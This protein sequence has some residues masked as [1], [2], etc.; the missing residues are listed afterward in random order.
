MKILL[1]C[2]SLVC[3]L[4]GQGPL[5]MLRTSS[6]LVKEEREVPREIDHDSFVNRVLCTKR[7]TAIS[8]VK[9]TSGQMDRQI[10][11]VLHAVPS[12]TL[13]FMWES[14]LRREY[15]AVGGRLES[16]TS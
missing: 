16:P 10:R 8:T 4:E 5:V 15:R 6:D 12:L 14:Q 1:T 9:P 3:R 11:V 13:A 7:V 2:P